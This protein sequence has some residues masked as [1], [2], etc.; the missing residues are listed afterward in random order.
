MLNISSQVNRDSCWPSMLKLKLLRET[1]LFLP[2]P[3]WPTCSPHTT[4]TFHLLFVCLKILQPSEPC[5]FYCQRTVFYIF[6]EHGTSWGPNTPRPEIIVALPIPRALETTMGK[7]A[8]NNFSHT[9]APKSFPRG[10]RIITPTS[11]YCKI[12]NII[13]IS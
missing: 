6:S 3:P 12:I 2:F 13:L 5:G 8:K 9:K 10:L 1:Y 7:D 4:H 11:L